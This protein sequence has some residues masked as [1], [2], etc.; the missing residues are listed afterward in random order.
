MS[1]RYTAIGWNPYKKRYDRV[2]AAS[3]AGYIALFAG[4]G[5]IVHPA[6]TVETLLIRAL[7][8]LAFLLLH[9]VLAIGPLCRL[10]PRFLPLLYNRRHLGVATFLAGLAHGAFSIV[11]FHAWGDV[12]PLTS[13]LTSN[14]RWSSAAQFPFELAGAS[15]LA[16]LFALAATSHDFWLHNLTPGVWKRIHMLVYIAYAL[17][18]AHVS[19]GALQSERSPWLAAILGAGLAT[20]C[21]LHL[22]AAAKERRLDLV[23]EK[24]AGFADL[25]PLDSIPEGRA[26]VFTLGGERIAVF[27][28]GDRVSAMSNVCRHQNGPLG[29]GKIVGGCVTCPWHGYQYDPDSGAAPPPFEDR[30]PVYPALV[31][32]GRVKVNPCPR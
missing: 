15:A 13:L 10:D 28:R 16:V 2:L 11:Q 3:M 6:A 9:V 8:T 19:L 5:A 27:R 20:L 30:V 18:V 12:N 22:A 1:V 4:L 25:C 31:V 29:E 14:P 17:L 21:I 26:R 23:P 24:S 7:G 32:E